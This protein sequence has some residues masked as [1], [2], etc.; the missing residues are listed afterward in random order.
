M[1]EV[2]KHIEG[3]VIVLDDPSALCHCTVS[4]GV[5]CSDGKARMNMIGTVFTGVSFSSVHLS[6]HFEDCIFNDCTF[7]NAHFQGIFKNVRFFFTGNNRLPQISGTG[8]HVPYLSDETR[9]GYPTYMVESF[10]MM[11]DWY[12]SA[13]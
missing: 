9:A 4:R 12:R 11:Q 8:E 7:E 10:G 1:N 13:A 6:G 5:I 2:G 3:R